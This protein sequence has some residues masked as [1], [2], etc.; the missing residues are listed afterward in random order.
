[1]VYKTVWEVYR[2]LNY[3]PLPDGLK[4]LKKEF[5]AFW[6]QNKAAF[7]AIGV[8]AAKEIEKLQTAKEPKLSHATLVKW[9]SA[10]E[11]EAEK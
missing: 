3:E 2:A 4:P 8:D 7:Q 6:R 5:Q 10:L 9:L 11:K 1:M